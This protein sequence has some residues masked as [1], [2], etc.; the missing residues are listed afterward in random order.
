M[1]PELSTTRAIET[2]TSV[3]WK[4]IRVCLT[5]SSNTSKFSFF[6]SGTSFVP[7]S[8]VALSTTSSTSAWR[9]YPSPPCL[10]KGSEDAPAASGERTGSR[11]TVSGGA[12]TGAGLAGGCCAG[13]EKAAPGKKTQITAE[14]ALLQRRIVA[15]ASMDGE[16]RQSGPWSHLNLHFTPLAVACQV[17]G[18]V[19]DEILVAQQGG[20][21]LADIANSG[22]IFNA[23]ESTAGLLTQLVQQL[24]PG[25]FLGGWKVGIEDSNRINLHVGLPHLRAQLALGVAGVV[26]GAIGN[27]QQSLSIVPRFL[28]LV[29][30]EINGVDQRGAMAASHCCQA[31]LEVFDRAGK[32]L[33]QLQAII[34]TDDKELIIRIGLLD[35]PQD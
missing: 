1:E 9:T 15:G 20:N 31:V 8:T 7:S 32:V 34:E 14:I 18:P 21:P 2:G 30:A 16:R 29:Q 25:A 19:A 6:R 12:W 22:E 10:R 4:L 13:S 28:H 11:S 5:P 27:H 3:C 23:E 35:E 33:D 24:W 17:R 26:V